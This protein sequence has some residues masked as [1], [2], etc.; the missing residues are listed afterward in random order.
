VKSRDRTGGWGE[1]LLVLAFLCLLIALAL[2]PWPRYFRTG[3]PDHFDPPF[4]AWKLQ[5]V[6]DQILHDHRL[7]PDPMTNIYY[8]Y[9]NELY[10]DA[11][12]WPQGMAAAL[13]K[14]LGCGP[15]LTYNLV[16]LFFWGLSGLFMYLLLRELSLGRPA[17]LFG[18]AALCLIPYRTS[19]Y[20]EFNMQMCFGLPLFLWCWLRFL[21]HPRAVTGF[22]LAV[23]VWLQAVSELYQAVILA[24]AFPFLFLPACRNLL[25]RHGRDRNLYLGAG[26]ALLTVLALSL[27]YLL[28]YFSLFQ[29]GGYA[30]SS[31]EM[32]THSLEPLA[33]LG[34]RIG[35][36]L[37]GA[38]PL[39]TVKTD[40]MDVFPSLTLLVVL[41]G[42]L[43]AR[44]PGRRVDGSGQGR[45]GLPD[46][47]VLLCLAAFFLLLAGL[48]RMNPSPAW[49]RMLL[50]GGNV[51]LLGALAL[52]VVAAISASRDQGTILVRGVTGAALFCFILSLGPVLR[53]LNQEVLAGNW[54]FSLVNR[55]FPLSGFRVMSRFSVVVMIALVL[56][57][58]RFL[59]RAGRGRRIAGLSLPLAAVLGL[60]T[61]SLVTPHPYRDFPL[62][63]SEPVRQVLDTGRKNSIVVVPLGDRYLDAR[64][65]LAIGDTD[66]LLVNG[67]GGFIPS[68]QIKIGRALGQQPRRALELIRA[69][70]PRP[71]VA[72]D[73][74]AL[75]PLTDQGY[76]TGE[77]LIRGQGELLARGPR[78]SVF[79]LYEPEENQKEYRRFLRVDLLRANGLYRFQARCLAGA[80]SRYLFVL[81]NGLVVDR[82]E[83][84]PD[85]QTYTVP[86]PVAGAAGV[87]Y[88]MVFLRGREEGTWSARRGTF[89]PGTVSDGAA[90]RE[91]ILAV[92]QAFGDGMPPDW[93]YALPEL[94]RMARP[95]AGHV[96]E[97]F[98]AAGF[99]LDRNRPAPGEEFSLF[100]Y[101]QIAPGIGRPSFRVRAEF[102]AR[103][104]RVFSAEFIP[105]HRQPSSFLASRPV[106]KLFVERLR[107]RVPDDFPPG[108]CRLRLVTA[109]GSGDRPSLLAAPG[110]PALRIRDRSA[111]NP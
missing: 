14:V 91:R 108:P 79:R 104:G 73:R 77:A 18:A 102:L 67:F 80:E 17:A 97:G 42:A 41:A 106:A 70:W 40:E 60:L 110:T 23:A 2:W 57:A 76:R 99:S 64:Y 66:N 89:L 46:R 47:L 103:D 87:D 36:W 33:Y 86:L 54:L 22:W 25:A 105:G 19:Y 7:L 24:L 34:E 29:G 81:F 62:R 15:I 85:W 107:L 8:P 59:D 21:R 43:L 50:A 28:P 37:C 72:V 71:L 92:N 45:G 13:L 69:V 12:L 49:G 39:A 38:D 53:V 111:A 52:G 101:W 9:A 98:R 83:L 44:R 75:A 88:E 11:L 1:S 84:T 65:M 5:V 74:K 10:F 30:R 4:H 109:S 55:V 3:F 96:A 56:L 58:A 35:R 61:E 6:A 82:V 32:M 26:L 48:C 20:V 93:V 78:F 94:P 95:L 31:R 90:D 27:P 63:I 100:T 51:L 68:L 16:L